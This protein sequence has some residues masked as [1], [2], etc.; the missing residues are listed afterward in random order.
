MV[1]QMTFEQGGGISSSPVS[2][3]LDDDDNYFISIARLDCECERG[4]FHQQQLLFFIR[5]FAHIFGWLIK[6]GGC[7]LVDCT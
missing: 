5:H 3:C 4:P 2:Q 1:F 6:V 7:V